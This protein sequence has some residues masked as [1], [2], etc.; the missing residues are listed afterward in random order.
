MPRMT[1]DEIEQLVHA[2]LRSLP[3]RRAPVTLEARVRDALERRAALPWWHRS[4]SHWPQAARAAFL[5][6]CG[7]VAVLVVLAGVSLQAGYD[8]APIREALAPISNLAD[9]LRVLGRVGGDFVALAGRYVPA[10]WLYGAVAFVAATY[11]MLFGLGAAAYRT[12]W[13]RR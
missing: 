4:W 3:D 10:W 2:A 13:V 9:R 5:L 12:L 8:P 11:A 6:L 7:G 1:P